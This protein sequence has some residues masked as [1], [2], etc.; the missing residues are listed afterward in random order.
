MAFQPMPHTGLLSTEQIH[1]QLTHER[2]HIVPGVSLCDETHIHCCYELYVNVEG[3]VSFLVNDHIYPLSQ[4]GAVLIRP[5]DVHVCV[6]PQDGEYEYYCLWIDD[7]ADV[8]FKRVHTEKYEPLLLCSFQNFQRLKELLNILEN[9]KQAELPKTAAFFEI[10]A[11]LNHGERDE[12]VSVST[13]VSEQM[14]QVLL[15]MNTGFLEI[16]NI[17]EVC[18]RFY[19]SQATLNR[20]FQKYAGVSPRTFLESKRLAYAK[21]LLSKG[22]TVTQAA[23]KAGF[24]DCSHFIRVF[25][26]KFGD[27]PKVYQRG[28]GIT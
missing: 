2:S 16:Q 8:L 23:S 25:K 22:D 9:E 19:I 7:G 28:N 27:T 24:S 20:W 1:Y 17:Q 10:L 18:D 11:L 21:Q 5:N 6:F 13:Q 3:D 4:G 12:K 15:Y 26:K 14:Q